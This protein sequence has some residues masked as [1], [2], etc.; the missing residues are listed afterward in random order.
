MKFQVRISARAERDVDD[1]LRWFQRERA[2][3][4]GA[5]WFAQ[6]LARIDTL[7]KQPVRCRSADEAA[8]V[9]IELRELLFG[10]RR[11][12]YRILFEIQGQVVHILRIRHAARDALIPDDL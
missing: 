11:G 6:L 12:M 2:T 5:R 4:A 7:E 1:V 8:D 10:R 3:A 9:G